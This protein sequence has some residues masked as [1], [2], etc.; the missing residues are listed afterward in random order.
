MGRASRGKKTR[1]EQRQAMEEFILALEFGEEFGFEHAEFDVV[2]VSSRKLD[3]RITD[4]MKRS[5]ESLPI[6][7]APGELVR[8]SGGL[9]CIPPVRAKFTNQIGDLLTFSIGEI[10][11]GMSTYAITIEK[12]DQAEPVSWIQEELIYLRASVKRCPCSDCEETLRKKE[13]E[14]TASLN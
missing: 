2:G 1:R 4:T 6:A 3:S 7:L 5:K 14:W 8:I 10:T 9:L 11:L 13:L 12:L